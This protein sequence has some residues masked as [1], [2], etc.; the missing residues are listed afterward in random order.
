[1]ADERFKF[2]EATYDIYWR[3]YETRK[4]ELCRNEEQ[5]QRTFTTGAKY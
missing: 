2:I 4:I 1:M 3:Q 5:N